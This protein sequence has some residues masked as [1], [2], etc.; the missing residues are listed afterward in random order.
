MGRRELRRCPKLVMSRITSFCGWSK[1][2]DQLLERDNDITDRE[3]KIADL[4]VDLATA[5]QQVVDLNARARDA[6][7]HTQV[8]DGGSKVKRTAKVDDPPSFYNDPDK[9]KVPFPLW[10]ML[11][12][13]KLT[14]NHD[15]F[16]NV[17]SELRYVTGRMAGDPARD[18]LPYMHPDKPPLH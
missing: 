1:L 5:N 16:L 17:M 11:V 18:I 9:D 8:T 3:Q 13:T 15:W 4:E 10:W 12:E 14:D 6:S 7:L 2:Q